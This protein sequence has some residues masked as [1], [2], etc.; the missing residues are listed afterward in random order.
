MVTGGIISYLLKE[1]DANNN[2]L[3]LYKEYPIE[4]NNTKSP[5]HI[6]LTFNEYFL[7]LA[8]VLLTS[9]LENNN[10]VKN[11]V[12]LHLLLKENFDKT[13]IDFLET[14]RKKYEVKIN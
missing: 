14:L 8:I 2:R 3:F 10:H 11:L 5:I 13:K 1:R 7:Y 9:L 4:K 6:C 12:V